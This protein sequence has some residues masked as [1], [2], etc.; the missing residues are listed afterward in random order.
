MTQFPQTVFSELAPS[1]PSRGQTDAQVA[2]VAVFSIGG[3]LCSMN[4]F[5]PR[6]P[7]ELRGAMSLSQEYMEF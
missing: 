3:W 6:G 7:R 4:S 5:S 1:Q 2:W